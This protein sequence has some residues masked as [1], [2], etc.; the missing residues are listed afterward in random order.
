MKKMFGRKITELSKGELISL[1]YNN[2]DI[3]TVDNDVECAVCGEND[4]AKFYYI[5]EECNK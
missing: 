4:K 5:C 1:V 2:L 3:S